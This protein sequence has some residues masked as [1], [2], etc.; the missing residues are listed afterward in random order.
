[1]GRVVILTLPIIITVLGLT[2]I[3]GSWALDW[4]RGRDERRLEKQRR[5][6]LAVE[7]S[8]RILDKLLE[9]A[10]REKV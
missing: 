3:I 7:E 6:L 8:N 10:R 1:M 5:E 2:Y 4:W 9:D